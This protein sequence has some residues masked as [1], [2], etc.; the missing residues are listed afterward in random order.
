M[1]LRRLRLEHFKRFREPLTIEGFADGLNLF[2]APNES[3]KSTIAEAIR[4]AFFERHRLTRV[5]HLRP[6]GDSTASPTIEVD[7]EIAGKAYHLVK[8]FLPRKR[9]DLLIDRRQ[10]LDGATAED[11]LAK[12][13][14]FSF[15]G[16]GANLPR[17]M[18]VPGLLWIRQGTSHELADAVSHAADHLRQV[19]GESLGD[20]ASSSGDTLLQAVKA[21]RDELLTPAGGSPRGDYQAALNH[22]DRL[23][24][25][26]E[27]LA[28][29]IDVYRDRVDRLATLRREQDKAARDRPW[30]GL[31]AQLQDAQNAL[32]E[33]LG[34]EARL[35]EEQASAQQWSARVA[36]LE[37]QLEGH[38]RED[39][40][41]L[42]R[43]QA[44][45]VATAAQAERQ[46]EVD[47]CERRHQDALVAET[48]A[49]ELRD[50][51]RAAAARAE[52]T[53]AV[54]EIEI[55][56]AK[57][58]QTLDQAREEA[59]RVAQL[60]SDAAQLAVSPADLDALRRLSGE[61][62]DVTVRLDAVATSVEFDLLEG[63]HARIGDESV[64]GRSRRTVVRRTAIEVE[65]IGHI[66]ITPGG[67]DLDALASRRDD[68]HS[69]LHALLARL[70]VE[71]VASAEARA[72]QSAQRLH[73]AQ[74]SRKVL[75][76]L[77][78]KGLE[79]LEVERAQS[80]QRLAELRSALGP[81]PDIPE[82]D[83]TLP[84]ADDAEDALERARAARESAASALNEARI[85]A[86]RAQSELTN[87]R[88]E[89]ATARA[90]VEDPQRA[91]RIAEARRALQAA[92]AEES[93][94]RARVEA[95]SLTSRTANVPVLRQDVE[96]YAKSVEQAVREHEHRRD[97]ISRLE[98]E[99]TAQGR[100]GQEEQLAELR[101]DLDTARRRADEFTRRAVAL[102]HLL[103]LLRE[104]RAELARRL[105]A[106]LQN[107][108]DRY[109]S[110]LFP[111]ATIEVADDLSPG[112]ITRAGSRGQESG[113]FED[114]SLGT[115]EQMGIVAR[116]AYADLLQEAG[117]PTLLILDDALVHTDEDRLGRMKRV[118]YDAATRHQ[119]L[120]FTCHPAAWR[121]LGVVARTIG[122]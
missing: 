48:G 91:E 15:P 120:I 1:K 4:A 34:L 21:A 95:V 42:K 92:L 44:V 50:R 19:L 64:R 104:K 82:S 119:I 99:L 72:E 49:R 89:L 54:A 83:V 43:A 2:A 16:A 102:D 84:S 67:T 11:Y 9:C 60:Q 103:S 55:A 28:R 108:L 27:S 62:R 107:H 30:E 7:F 52:H 35:K 106:P 65:G 81:R 75:E 5:E 77:A 26:V 25:Q 115:R 63:H 122:L 93:A 8:S 10:A 36:A 29:D 69:Q 80:Q 87:A 94:A 46:T 41:V 68:L 110:I 57:L 74:G 100:L 24:E 70:G 45:D 20:M 37:A 109:L 14:G 76:A 23:S 114:L 31:R 101:R 13:F 96:R 78:P 18:G 56:L 3:G 59:A 73:E 117:K 66:V 71:N 113:E 86:A 38:A 47:A 58:D 112:I 118:L 17:H 22:R 61:L 97:E 40:A 90:L 88:Q 32:D 51:V 85:A 39:S 33:A 116:L 98:G 121:D 111:G 12:L 53:R 6:W 79:A 105:R